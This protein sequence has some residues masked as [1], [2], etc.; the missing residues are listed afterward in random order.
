MPRGCD[1]LLQL[2]FPED[3]QPVEVFR[4]WHD[5]LPAH[6]LGA[7]YWSHSYRDGRRL[8]ARPGYRVHINGNAHYV[9]FINHAWYRL[10]KQD[11]DFV[12]RRSHR[13][14]RENSIGL[15]W[16]NSDDEENPERLPPTTAP[17]PVTGDGPHKDQL[18]HVEETIAVVDPIEELTTAFAQLTPIHVDAAL[19]EEDIEPTI[20]LAP[21]PITPT[22]FATY[23]VPAI[24]AVPVAPIATPAMATAPL[25]GAFKGAIPTTFAGNRAE[26]EQ[27]IRE[28]RQFHR[29]NRDHASILSPYLRVGLACSFVRGPI[30]NDWVDLMER[31]LDADTT[32]TANPVAET[33]EVLWT[34]FEA[35]FKSA[36]TDTLS[37]QNAYQQLTTLVMSGDNIDEYIATFE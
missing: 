27:F 10:E 23:V 2:Q 29:N 17:E 30:V 37:K 34:N 1:S 8:N 12:T 6:V 25:T 7:A 31:T 3:D 9:E 13:I 15:G 19:I 32:R 18:E 26:S 11:D 5:D 14:A 20:N 35:S 21:V 22:I 28:F 4:R 36:W 16:W 24:P 33:D